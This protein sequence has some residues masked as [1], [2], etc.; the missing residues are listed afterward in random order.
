MPRLCIASRGKNHIFGSPRGYS[1]AIATNMWDT[2]SGTYLSM[3]NVSQIRLA[4]S[5]E[6]VWNRQ[7]DE[8]QTWGLRGG[9]KYQYTL[10]S[11]SFRLSVV[12]SL[13]IDCKDKKG[14]SFFL[15]HS[16]GPF[17]MLHRISWHNRPADAQTVHG[18]WSWRWSI[19]SP[20]RCLSLPKMDLGSSTRRNVLAVASVR[21]YNHIHRTLLAPDQMKRFQH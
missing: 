17:W 21:F 4:V 19:L 2:V 5:E 14:A 1:R 7:I 20:S 12:V 3:Q 13:T 11:F 16:V 15:P 10:H 6:M 8:Q 18:A 9:D